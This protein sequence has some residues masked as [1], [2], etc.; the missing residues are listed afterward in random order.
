[1][2]IDLVN[3]TVAMMNPQEQ[4]VAEQIAQPLVREATKPRVFYGADAIGEVVKREGD[5]TPLQ[6]SVVVEE[7]FVDGI[8]EDDAADSGIAKKNVKTAG[9]GQTGKYIDMSFKEAFDD[10]LQEAKKMFPGFDDLSLEKQEAVMSTHYRGDRRLKSGKTAKWVKLFNEGKYEKAATEL[11]DHKEYKK[12]KSNN[13]N[14]GV[15]KR[16]ERASMNI[17]K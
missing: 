13:P 11:L 2:D 4:V 5:L 8:Y 15:V 1:M 6:A 3:Q 16:L 12:R 17:A 7:G 14:D 9:V 10:K